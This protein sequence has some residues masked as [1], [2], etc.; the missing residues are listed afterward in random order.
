MPFKTLLGSEDKEREQ[1][2][3]ISENCGIC[4]ER[5]TVIHYYQ[6]FEFSAKYY[7]P[8]IKLLYSVRSINNN[9]KKKCRI[10]QH[11]IARAT[12]FIEYT[13][14]RLVSPIHPT[15][16]GWNVIFIREYQGGRGRTRTTPPARSPVS[17][18]RV[19]VRTCARELYPCALI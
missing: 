1:T 11:N 9:N 3:N 7:E 6:V 8:T 2:F 18:A 10:K 12:I 17:G 16:T 15:Y 19:S 5:A 4:K 13:T 14:I